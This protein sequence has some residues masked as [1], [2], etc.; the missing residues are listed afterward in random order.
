WGSRRCPVG[1][2]P[3]RTHELDLAPFDLENPMSRSRS[4]STTFWVCLA[5]FVALVSGCSSG[6]S[7]ALSTSAS[8]AGETD[9][10]VLPDSG[11][12]DAGATSDG[13]INLCGRLLVDRVRLVVRRID[14]ER[15][16]AAADGGSDGGMDA[17]QGDGGDAGSR[18]DDAEHEKCECPDGG[19]VCVKPGG[20]VHIGPF[21][22]DAQG[23]QLTDGIH[24]VFD[25]DI[26]QGT[27][28]EVRFVINTVSRHQAVDGGLAEMQ[29][30]PASIAA[31]GSFQGSPFRF[32]TSI[33]VAQ[34]QQGPFVVGDGT[35]NVTLVVD[36]S[37][38]FVGKDGQVL[39]PN[40]PVNRGTIKANIRCSIRMFSKEARSDGGQS[41]M[42]E[43][44]DDD[45]GDK[46]EAEDDDDDDQGEDEGH[47]QKH[48]FDRG[49]D[50]GHGH[51]GD[52]DHGDGDHGDGEHGHHKVCGSTPA[53]M[54][55]DGGSPSDGGMDGGMDG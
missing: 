49:G 1:L 16:P 38:W 10:G 37:G 17:G 43:F 46:C 42:R 29:S 21:L 45:R 48:S 24:E 2:G 11:V 15:A 20:N 41:F 39:D 31:D 6:S 18:D 55:G 52:G 53:L 34:K 23:S 32:T 51:H 5:G 19:M 8:P 35:K 25:V 26:P 27:Y 7:L 12:A 4:S 47:G 33:R 30:L 36:P 13:G 9:S 50:H 44:E 3:S 54:C 14:L 22:V 40:N 28:E